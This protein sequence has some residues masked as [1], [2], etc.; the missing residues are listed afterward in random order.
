MRYLVVFIMWLWLNPKIHAKFM[1]EWEH[2]FV[3]FTFL[4]LGMYF[5]MFLPDV[6]LW[7]FFCNFFFNLL[8]YLCCLWSFDIVC[9]CTNVVMSQ[10]FQV[11]LLDLLSLYP[12]LSDVHLD[13][14]FLML[15]RATGRD[16]VPG[17]K[18][19]A[20]NRSGWC[21]DLKCR[22]EVHI[23]VSV[24]QSLTSLTSAKRMWHD[25]S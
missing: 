16:I 18:L 1:S 2:I 25:K 5:E 4:Q 24:L 8:L 9:V 19:V 22:G 6:V 21:P 14:F 3:V 10:T 12:Q 13:F 11:I 23:C 7:V 20:G 17:N 15:W